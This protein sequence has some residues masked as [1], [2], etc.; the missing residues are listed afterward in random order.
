MGSPLCSHHCSDCGRRL[1]SHRSA[2]KLD[3]LEELL[4]TAVGSLP[5]STS[6]DRDGL[7]SHEESTGDSNG[8]GIG[9]GLEI[10]SAL[11]SRIDHTSSKRCA[12]QS[13]ATARV[14]SGGID[15]AA[16]RNLGSRE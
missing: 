12:S 4:A 14:D 16:L 1:L 10:G 13:G 7:V 8:A 3:P 9:C 2:G 5:G 11:Q 15:A 6:I